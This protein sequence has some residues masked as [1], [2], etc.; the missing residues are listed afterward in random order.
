MVDRIVI[1]RRGKKGKWT[2]V[3]N[4]NKKSRGLADKTWLVKLQ[5][6]QQTNFL[7]STIL[8][9]IYNLCYHLT[10]TGLQLTELRK[11]GRQRSQHCTGR[12]ST[13]RDMFTILEQIS[14]AAPKARHNL[15]DEM[16]HLSLLHQPFWPIH[17]VITM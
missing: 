3:G 9:M 8:T 10:R 15:G 12:M 13:A 17:I 6:D 4:K 7:A 1:Q 16:Y 14:E 2:S 11:K 5:F